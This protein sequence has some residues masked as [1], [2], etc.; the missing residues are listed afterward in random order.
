[1]KKSKGKE[2]PEEKKQL[3]FAIPKIYR[4][5]D[6]ALDN[7]IIEDDYDEA[8]YKGVFKSVSFF[9]DILQGVLLVE[10]GEAFKIVFGLR[11]V[12]AAKQAQLEKVPAT[13]FPAGTPKEVFA[14]FV[15]VENMNRAPNPALEAEAL[16]EVMRAYDWKPTDVAKNLGVMAAHVSARIKLLALTPDIFRKLKEGRISLSLARKLCKLSRDK[17]TELA[18]SEYLT[19][20]VVEEAV[21]E[22]NLGAFIPA[23]LFEMPLPSA[24]EKENVSELVKEA[25][26][27]IEKAIAVTTNGIKGELSKALKALKRVQE[28]AEV[29]FNGRS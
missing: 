20:D 24:E 10:N 17:Q 26:S 25:M 14:S 21:K 5:E 23:E 18:E 4:R 22:R 12:L 27:K 2:G 3:S 6:V 9:K 16:D 15:V 13:I 29:V 11:R 28:K 7:I 8:F 1:M 19:L